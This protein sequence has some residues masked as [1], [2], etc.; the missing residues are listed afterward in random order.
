MARLVHISMDVLVFDD[1]T[2]DDTIKALAVNAVDA[3]EGG[4]LLDVES[5]AASTASPLG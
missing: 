3:L 2:S 5:A 1:W 4:A